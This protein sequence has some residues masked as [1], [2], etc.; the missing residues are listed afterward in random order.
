MG[1]KISRSYQS[2]MNVKP[3]VTFRCFYVMCRNVTCRTYVRYVTDRNVRINVTLRFLTLRYVRVEN[4][5]KTDLL[6][7]ITVAS[8]LL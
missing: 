4:T 8:S 6:N 1:K 3:Y 5:H 2:R 7:F